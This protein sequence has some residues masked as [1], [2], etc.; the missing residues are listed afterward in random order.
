MSD[1]PDFRKVR[2]DEAMKFISRVLV[3]ASGSSSL[4]KL[5]QYDDN[6]YR[7]VFRPEYFK[8]D[9]DQR[10]PSKSQWNTLKKRMKRVNHDVFVFKA[11]GSINCEATNRFDASGSGCYYIDFGFFAH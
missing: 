1:L 4:H 2:R 9:D 3:G 5:L 6:H 10:E 7:A 8:L 11:H